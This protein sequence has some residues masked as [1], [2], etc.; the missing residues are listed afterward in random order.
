MVQ[1]SPKAKPNRQTFMCQLTYAL[2]LK[3]VNQ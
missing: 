2:A 1:E 3:D